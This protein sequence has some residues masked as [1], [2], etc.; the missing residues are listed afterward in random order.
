MAFRWID[1][2]YTRESS[3]RNRL[4][5][6]VVDYA[7]PEN[8]EIGVDGEPATYD[9]ILQWGT[10][11]NSHWSE[12]APCYNNFDNN[13]VKGDDPTSCSSGCGTRL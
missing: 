6:P 2:Q 13:N 12:A 4:G 5:E 11:Q 1:S 8:G 7:I 10:V 3:M 9:P